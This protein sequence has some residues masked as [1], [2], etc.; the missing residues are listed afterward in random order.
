MKNVPR[1]LDLLKGGKAKL[2]DWQGLVKVPIS[3]SL[4]LFP[5]RPPTDALPK[6]TYHATML[7][8]TMSELHDSVDVDVVRRVSLMFYRDIT[9]TAFSS[10][11]FWISQRSKTSA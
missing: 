2:G 4:Y 1:I 8:D 6:F 10:L 7:R 11:L 5:V 3:L 9:L